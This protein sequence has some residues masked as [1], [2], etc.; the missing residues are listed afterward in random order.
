[1][2]C[3]FSVSITETIFCSM[4][5]A[6][7]VLSCFDRAEDQA[8]ACIMTSRSIVLSSG[9]GRST[10]KVSSDENIGQSLSDELYARLPPCY[11]HG[12][13]VQIGI[14]LRMV[15]ARSRGPMKRDCVT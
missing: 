9:N 6:A 7:R 3:S 12:H 14:K 11:R 1:M 13:E 15:F 8:C 5:C 4:F 10:G 2:P